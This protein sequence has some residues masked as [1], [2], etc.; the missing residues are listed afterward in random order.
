MDLAGSFLLRSSTDWMK[1]THI[2]EGNLLY[3]TN[4]S[5][6]LISK[7][8]FTETWKLVFAWTS[9]LHS[10]AKRTHKINNHRWWTAW[11]LNSYCNVIQALHTYL[12][13]DT[14]SFNL[15]QKETVYFQVAVKKKKDLTVL[16]KFK[17]FSIIWS[18][19]HFFLTGVEVIGNFFSI[20]DVHYLS[21]GSFYKMPSVPLQTN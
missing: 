1:H 21:R 16:R 15:K 3:S 14:L 10:L 5:V 12:I 13:R 19:A 8:T 7:N 11:V 17:L 4:L 18:N 20:M 6:N 2:M 9:G